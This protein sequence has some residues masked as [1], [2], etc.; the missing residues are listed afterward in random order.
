MEHLIL[1]P[2][3]FSIRAFMGSVGRRFL[4]FVQNIG[5]VTKL[6]GRTLSSL[7]RY[8]LDVKELV[9]QFAV[10]GN[11]S[12]MIVGLTAIFTGMVIALQLCI[13]LGRY[14]LKLNVGQIV[15]LSIFRELGPVLTCLM[16]AARVGSGIAAEIG[17]MVVTEQVLAIEA[18]GANPVSKLV[19]PRV[20]ATI[21]ACPLLST[22]ADVIGSFGGMIIT[23]REAGVSAHF[24]LDQIRTTVLVED[25]MSGVYKTLFFGFAISIISCYEGLNTRGG[26][27]GVGSATTRAVVFSSIVI[28]I[29]DFFL[30]KLIVFL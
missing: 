11:R 21:I 12:L 2:S 1:T 16:V 17:S 8:R 22:I 25:F 5:G 27:E 19:V 15:G 10:I 24:F 30:T 7:F 18:M 23:V 3:I 28:F 29:S 6:A 26:T 4:N 9:R 13:G 14:G 20:L